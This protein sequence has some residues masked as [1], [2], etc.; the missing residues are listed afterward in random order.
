MTSRLACWIW[1]AIYR[2]HLRD[3]ERV[4]ALIGWRTARVAN[5]WGE[6]KWITPVLWWLK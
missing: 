3:G 2:S 5:K 1:T 6:V 4:T